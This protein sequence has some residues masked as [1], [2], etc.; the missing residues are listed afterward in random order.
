[1]SPQGESE[2]RRGLAYGLAAYLLWGIFPLYY[3]LLEPAGPVEILAN[4]IVWSLVV[5]SLLLLVRRRWAWV[6]PL[7]ADRR[8]LLLLA[9][10]AV[11]I[12]TNWGFYV[13]G[14]NSN[15]VVETSLGYFINP[16]VS[17]LFGVV[18]FREH[19]R[20]W[21][22]IAVG[23]GAI[24]VVVIAVDYG[25]IPWIALILAF[26]FGTYGLLKKTI[27]MGSLES[28]S[29]ETA[30]LFLPAMAFLVLLN[31]HGV[32]A[33]Q[34]EGAS[35]AAL[36]ATTG[37]VT[38]IPLLFFGA[39]ATRIPLTWIGLLQYTAPVLQFVIGVTI[40]NEPMPLSRL[41]GFALVW[42]ALGILA[43]D[44]L[45][46]VR[47]GRQVDREETGIDAPEAH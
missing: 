29:V 41:I 12:A 2:Q 31:V 37:L 38:T 18:L 35:S 13:Y 11:V 16:L 32:S 10:A 8:R 6:R 33:L 47:R 26:S 36:L 7:L 28:L 25:R 17:I 42:L 45:A 40:Y 5:V 34:Q 9:A 27:G 21:Q 43:V 39:A 46:A 30:I 1:V 14:V 20:R 4:R 44:S 24:A 23:I 22:W 19:L 15:Q 3:P